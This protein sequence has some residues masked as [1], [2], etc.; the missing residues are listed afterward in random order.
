MEEKKQTGRRQV[1]TTR[2]MVT[3]HLLLL[4][5]FSLGALYIIWNIFYTQTL[6]KEHWENEKNILVERTDKIPSSRGDIYSSD[7]MLFATNIHYYRLH[8]DPLTE[9]GLPLD[10]LKRYIMPLSRKL[11]A[12]FKEKSA[13]EYKKMILS[14]RKRKR[15]YLQI[16]K[17][18]LTY[19]EA[20][21]IK[22][23]PIFNRGQ[24]RGGIILKELSYRFK[25]LGALASRTIG[26][27]AGGDESPNIRA[28][29][30]GLEKGLD[31]YLRGEE[32]VGI[33]EKTAGRSVITTALK[34]AVDGA[35]VISTISME[36]QD[37]AHQAL[38]RKLKK[39]QGEY[40]SVIVMEVQSGKIRS[41][42]NLQRDSN[43]N[44][45]HESYNFA[46]GSQGCR[47]PGSTFK[48]IPLMIAIEASGVELT[49]EMY[50]GNGEMDY[51]G[52]IIRDDYHKKEVLTIEEI[53]AYSSNVG[54]T[55]MVLKHYEKQPK[56]F[57]DR[58][59]N[60]GLH[61]LALPEIPGL[62][63]PYIPDPGNPNWW[64]TTLAWTSFG[65]ESRFTPL[66]LLALYNAIA[67]NGVFI[68]PTVVDKITFN[69]QSLSQSSPQIINPAI[70]TQETLKKVQQCLQAVVSYGTAKRIA[71]TKYTIAGKTGTSLI[72][73]QGRYLKGRYRASFAGYFPAD[74][75]QFSA[76][77]IV[78]D[79]KRDFYGTVVAA[80]VFREIADFLYLRTNGFG[81][82]N[83]DTGQQENCSIKELLTRYAKRVDSL[84][85][86]DSVMPELRGFTSGEA[87]GI[88]YAK[89]Y[90]VTYKGRGRVERQYPPAGTRILPGAIVSLFFDNS[91]Q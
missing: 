7:G 69:G 23:F 84:Q 75:P 17:R 59:Y 56:L 36:L 65:Y 72:E 19:E 71:S 28:G 20:Q 8:M 25:P 22:T 68:A 64:G 88:L 3:V 16:S 87:I 50:V 62:A 13:V 9:E 30:L 38:L 12:F 79:P 15:R 29:E 67:N 61:R 73:H 47:S 10:T 32:G 39:V 78:H 83:R 52:E 41:I 2:R 14:A 49:D 42:V 34:P 51:Q 46:V 80:P 53:I 70:C 11:S 45:Y 91:I 74:K 6:N 35:D 21:Y 48:V 77:V 27:M 58:M 66:H 63:K 5:S 24:F 85:R 26:R 54:I 76:Y 31:S 90:K 33:R 18:L 86:K 89:G 82:E 37:F 44:T 57:I 55:K 81:Q 40:G 1:A 60:I 4:F 43:T